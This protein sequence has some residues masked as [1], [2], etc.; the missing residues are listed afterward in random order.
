[1]VRVRCVSMLAL[2]TLMACAHT[3][4]DDDDVVQIVGDSEPDEA[5]EGADDTLDDLER[6]F[7]LLRQG[8][9]GAARRLLEGA[10]A[11]FDDLALAS[12]PL[13]QALASDASKPYRGRPHERVLAAT[14]LAALDMER[15]RCDLAIPT[16]RNAAYL[17]ARTRPDEASDAVLVH[18]LALRCLERSNAGVSDRERARGELKQALAVS[19]DEARFA[20]LEAVALGDVLVLVLDGAGPTIVA[21]GAHGERARAVPSPTAAPA[22]VATVVIPAREQVVRIRLGIA[23]SAH[24]V[25]QGLVVWSSTQQATTIGGRPYDEVLARRAQQKTKALA[26]GQ[27]SLQRGASTVVDASRRRDL[28]GLVAGA[29]FAASGAGLGAVGAA[30]DARADVRCVR[31][32][33]ERA[34]LLSR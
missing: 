29:L 14:V 31:S 24:K 18:A 15:G 22:R 23:A 25:S 21:D 33:F 1:M 12:T 9:H 27:A 11:R 5:I 3:R 17:D 19:G 8:K 30:T 16:L 13:E 7:A 26:D 10:T 2:A 34:S 6:A 32:L 20:E 28:K 4:D